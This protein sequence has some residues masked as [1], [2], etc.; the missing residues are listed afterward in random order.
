MDKNDK[1]A[2][3]NSFGILADLI[4]DNNNGNNVIKEREEE[5]LDNCHA[6][7]DSVE[8]SLAISLIGGGGQIRIEEGLETVK[9]SNLNQLNEESEA[10]ELDKNS[11]VL[12]LQPKVRHSQSP[13][14]NVNQSSSHDTYFHDDNSWKQDKSKKYKGLSIPM[15]TRTHSGV[16]ILP[17]NKYHV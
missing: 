12:S 9:P 13:I 4:D 8:D 6:E 11:K 3:S 16:P 14:L 15:A 5:V 2:L 10:E 7:K 1:Q 17:P